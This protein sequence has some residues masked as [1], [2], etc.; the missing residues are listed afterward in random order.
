[1]GGEEQG[2]D[3]VRRMRSGIRATL[4]RVG[5]GVRRL[6]PYGLLALLSAGAFAPVLAV[7]GGLTAVGAVAAIG[8]LG[9]VGANVLTNLLSGAIDHLRQ[10]AGGRDLERGE[11]EQELLSRIEAALAGDDDTA[12]ALRAELAGVLREIGMSQAA[13]EEV[14]QSGNQELQ[15]AMTD[16]FAKLSTD[17]AEFGFLLTDLRNA[18]V[19]IQES[20]Q[21]QYVANEADRLRAR[22]QS[23]QLELVGE[24]LATIERL[25]RYIYGTVVFAGSTQETAKAVKFEERYRRGVREFLD[26]VELFGLDLLRVP[27]SYRLGAAY[28]SLL[29]ERTGNRSNSCTPLHL[30]DLLGD[31]HRI[32]LEGA[33]GTGKST[34]LRYLALRVMDGNLPG[35]DQVS[36]SLIPF[37]L[38]LRSF[39][40]DGA[41]IL[42]EHSDD[43]INTVAWPLNK[44]KPEGWVSNLLDEGRAL[45][46]IDGIDEIREAHRPIM[47]KWLRQL[48]AAYPDAFYV[49]TSRPAAIQEAL[50]DDLRAGGF[51]T[52][53]LEPMTNV[54]VDDFIDR[55]YHAATESDRDQDYLADVEL[56]AVGLKSSLASRPD[57]HSLAT[58]PLLCAVICAVNLSRRHLPKRRTELYDMAL[59]LLLER[60]DVV[61]SIRGSVQLSRHESRLMLARLAL[62]MLINGQYSIP[63]APALTAITDLA[64]SFGESPEYMLHQMLEQTGLLQETGDNLVEFRY[65]SFQDYLAATEIIRQDLTR[66]LVANSRDPAYHDVIVNVGELAELPLKRQLIAALISKAEQA[67]AENGQGRQLWLLAADCIGDAE[68]MDDLA[69]Q[70][71]NGLRQANVGT[72]SD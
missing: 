26:R 62:W 54:Q 55:W 64:H 11:I 2:S 25:T 67:A 58:T 43:F 49:A 46:L 47:L 72:D 38:E 63:R 22:Q 5:P 53:K 59:E 17:F 57:L 42:P 8:L 29:L 7:A 70:V 1:M 66:Y 24:Q 32:L 37:L 69:N 9:N 4:L 10:T 34:V 27:R 33:A 30:E 71:R 31:N 44:E 13:L 45:V 16:S 20:L 19:T 48:I 39:V 51:T 68:M 23:A 28:V 21:R 56:L 35:F 12:K 52:A 50:R 40:R 60:R 65:L 6:S 14:I 3:T 18:T 15:S 61:R 41:L 36:S